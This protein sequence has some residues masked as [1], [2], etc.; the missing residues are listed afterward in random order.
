MGGSLQLTQSNAFAFGGARKGKVTAST[1]TSDESSTAGNNTTLRSDSPDHIH[2]VLNDSSTIAS[3][4]R[5]SDTGRSAVETDSSTID[6]H[7]TGAPEPANR[8]RPFA[9]FSEPLVTE[10]KKPRM[11][12]I[13]NFFKKK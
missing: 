11:R 5:A 8:K 7:S 13:R 9:E 1:A 3:S 4:S 10:R 2:P 6:E 12:D